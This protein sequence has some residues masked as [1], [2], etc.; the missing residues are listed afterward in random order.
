M[1]SIQ[2]TTKTF[3][4]EFHEPFAI[5]DIGKI[6]ERRHSN[7]KKTEDFINLEVFTRP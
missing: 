6:S 1:N 4:R 7:H 2:D 3:K 5:R